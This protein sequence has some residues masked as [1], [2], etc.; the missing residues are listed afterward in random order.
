MVEWLEYPIVMDF[1]E[2]LLEAV[3]IIFLEAGREGSRQ[4]Q[5]RL[6]TPTAREGPQSNALPCGGFK[7]RICTDSRQE[8]L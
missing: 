8:C 3:R 5:N 1:Q 2:R 4:R 7:P 6:V